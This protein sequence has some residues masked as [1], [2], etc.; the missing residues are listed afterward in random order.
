MRRWPRGLL[1]PTL[2]ALLLLPVLASADVLHVYDGL[3]RLRATVDPAANDAAV[4]TYDAVGNILAITRQPATQ[5]TILEIPAGAVAGACGVR[6]LGIGF[7]P[8]PGQNT[9]T[10]NGT[11]ATVQSATATELV[12]CLGGSTTTGP[13]VVTTPT[14]SDTADTSLPVQ[15]TAG[16]PTITGFSPG[17]AVWSTA[18]SLTGANF[19]TG[20]GRTRVRLGASSLLAPVTDVT[21]TT[22]GTTVPAGAT[23]GRVTVTTPAGTGTAATDLFIPPAPYV[24]SDVAVTGRVALGAGQSVTLPALKQALL[25]FDGTVGQKVCVGHAFSSG[26]GNLV[27]GLY[28]PNGISMFSP[29]SGGDTVIE[30]GPLP[31]AGTY[32]IQL[33]NASTTTTLTG[34]ATLYDASGQLQ[35]TI[36]A[37]GTATTVT[38]ST[39]CARAGRTFAGTAGQRV[40]LWTSSAVNAS[41][42]ITIANPDGTTLVTSSIG[43]SASAFIVEPVTLPQTGT[44]TLWAD[45]AGSGTGTLTHWLY[46]VVDITATTT[47]NAAPLSVTTAPTPGARVFISVANGTA[48]QLATVRMTSNTIGSM[49]V[50]L[51]RPDGTT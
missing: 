50:S 28:Q 14:G 1:G 4:W 47:I 30:S 8:T 33:R 31:A 24:A 26:Y 45:P 29:Y 41:S 2:L 9:V 6:L 34:T 16:V 15:A 49:T 3:N 37:N 5:T 46:T 27:K 51:L 12:V 7:S 21:A 13:V 10:V 32:Q 39:P 44:Y 38:V 17:I 23:S 42:A 35:G 20:P 48:G 36:P 22:L 43:T 19:E 40:S 11:A 18:L 25:V